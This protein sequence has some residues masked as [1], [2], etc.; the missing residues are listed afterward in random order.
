MICWIVAMPMPT[1]F[2][3]VVNVRRPAI[4]APHIA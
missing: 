1:S 2:F 3:L 4:Q